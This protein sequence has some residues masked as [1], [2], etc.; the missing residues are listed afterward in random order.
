MISSLFVLLIWGVKPS[1]SSD[2]DD[3][4][5]EEQK[6]SRVIQSKIRYQKISDD[7]N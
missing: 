2:I 5:D 6:D 3:R 7:R 4:C 1:G